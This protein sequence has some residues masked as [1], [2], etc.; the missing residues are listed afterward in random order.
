LNTTNSVNADFNIQHKANLTSIGT[1]V[2]IPLYF[3]VN[4]GTN[5]NNARIMVLT[6]SG[7]MPV[8]DNAKDL[9]ST[10]L[11]WRNIYTN[12]LKLSNKGSENDVDGTWGDYTIQEGYEDLFL[13]NHRTGKK[14]KFNLTEVA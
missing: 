9:G 2:N 1:G 14:F 12:D 5:A 7:L 10:S 4:G 11:R 6:G 3:H 8:S 13:I